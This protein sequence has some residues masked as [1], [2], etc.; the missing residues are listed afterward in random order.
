MKAEYES[1]FTN[2]QLS[3]FASLDQ[4]KI[5]RERGYYTVGGVKYD[6][7]TG[8]ALGDDEVHQINITN[9]FN[10][11]VETPATAAKKVAETVEAA[12]YQ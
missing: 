12:L 5:N 2:R 6:Y 7:Y 1:Q 8:E 11:E 9:N 4:D 10:T 3:Y